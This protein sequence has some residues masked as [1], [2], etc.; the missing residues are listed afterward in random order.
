MRVEELIRQEC[1]TDKTR[2]AITDSKSKERLADGY[3]YSDE[4][5]RCA[6]REIEV[7]CWTDNGIGVVAKPIVEG[8]K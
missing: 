3:W 4:I 2:I 1:V 6:G 5:L 8:G 7:F